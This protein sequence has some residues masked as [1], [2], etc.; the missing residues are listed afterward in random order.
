VRLGKDAV[1]SDTSNSSDDEDGSPA[2]IV[3]KKKDFLSPKFA[4]S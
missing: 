3:N 4:G 2:R 1:N